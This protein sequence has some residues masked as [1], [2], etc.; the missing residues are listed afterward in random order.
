MQLQIRL[1]ED[2]QNQLKK[3]IEDQMPFITDLLDLAVLKH[4]YQDNKFELCFDELSKRY[5]RVRRL[6]RDGNCFYRAFLFQ[7][8]EHFILNKQDP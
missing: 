3:D 4:E 7:V 2:Y 5:T 8:F 6:R 1:N